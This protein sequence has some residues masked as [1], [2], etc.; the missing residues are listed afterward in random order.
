LIRV[1]GLP[2]A[3]VL[4]LAGCASTCPEDPVLDT[5]LDTLMSYHQAFVCDDKQVEYRC[6]SRQLKSGFGGLAGYSIG[7]GIV[8]D[9]NPWLVRFARFVDLEEAVTVEMLPGGLRALAV[10]SLGE[11]ALEVV[12]VYEPEYVLHHADGTTTR[13]YA[14]GVDVRETPEG[15][16]VEVLDPAYEAESDAPLLRR[17]EI[18]PRWVLDWVPGIEQAMDVAAERPRRPAASP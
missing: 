3:V 5:P 8:R 9:E 4:L 10:V 1:P 13:G 15:P 17:V 11:D 2:L 6:L 18:R 16:V 12:L 7:R 14:D